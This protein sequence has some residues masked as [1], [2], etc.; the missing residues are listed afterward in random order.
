MSS[1]GPESSTRRRRSAWRAIVGSLWILVAGVCAV[2]SR[3]SLLA[4][5]PAYPIVIAVCALVGL[6][7]VGTG[8]RP[9]AADRPRHRVATGIGRGHAALLT[10]VV[11]GS[12]V[13]LV[14][15]TAAPEAVAVCG[16]AWETN[17][18]DTRQEPCRVL[19]RH[20]HHRALGRRPYRGGAVA[21]ARVVARPGLAGW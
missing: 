8:L 11:L 3:G 1:S 5:H 17:H 13:Y 16:P 2:L 18:F 6:W 19:D 15:A 21:I 7:L 10:L 4:G 14:P 9:V 20:P 12:L